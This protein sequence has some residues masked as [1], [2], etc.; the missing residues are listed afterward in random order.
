MLKEGKRTMYRKVGQPLRERYNEFLGD[1]YY[2][3]ILE[4]RSTEV[5]RAQT[6]LLVVLAALFQPSESQMFEEDLNWQPIPIE[7]RSYD[8]DLASKS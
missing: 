6:S 4:A 5:R 7:Y 1:I 3:G 8:N 2:P